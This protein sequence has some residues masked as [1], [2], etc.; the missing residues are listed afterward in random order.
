MSPDRQEAIQ[1]TSGLL[2]DLSP[3]R[4]FFDLTYLS[5]AAADALPTPITRMTVAAPVTMSPFGVCFNVAPFIEFQPGALGEQ[6][7]VC[8]L[9][10][11]FYRGAGLHEKLASRDCHRASAAGRVQ[12][13]Q[14]YL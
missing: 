14:L 6:E 13:A 4:T 1:L 7:F 3:V 5:I 2:P 12:I 8:S 10:Y 9:T 11:G